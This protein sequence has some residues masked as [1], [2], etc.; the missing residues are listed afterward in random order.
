MQLIGRIARISLAGVLVFFTGC[1]SEGDAGGWSGSVEAL[2]NGAV[3]VVNPAEGLWGPEAEWSLTNELVLGQIEGPEEEVFS[4]L[5][6]LEVDDEGRIYVLDRDLN[7]LRIFSP[8]GEH[9]RSVGGPG[10][11]PGEFRAANG[12]EWLPG[13]SLL[14]ID[15]R[16]NRYSVFSREGEFARSAPRG[17]SFYAWAFRGGV[18]GENR[19]GI[20]EVRVYEMSFVP[21]G[22]ERRPALLGVPLGDDDGRMA[23]TPPPGTEG[24]PS[25]SAGNDTILLPV[26]NV[27]PYESY[28]V[29][30]DRGGMSMGVPFAP[31][32]VYHLG[33]ILEGG[34]GGLWHGH[35]SEFRIFHSFLQ[36]DTLL[37]IVVDTEPVPVSSE[38]ISEF[39]ASEAAGRFREMGGDLDLGR[40]PEFKPF[41]EGLYQDPD[42]YLWVSI[43]SEPMTVSFAVIDPDG[44]YLGRL[45]LSGFERTTFIDPVVRNGRLHLV[46]SDELGVQYVQVF[47]I[48]R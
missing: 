11:G 8:D 43:P 23:A 47:R 28:S 30:T 5:I 6:A 45:E 25:A 12:L 29:R 35:G 38:E 3:R 4:N 34:K 19:D 32:S 40:I 20:G 46:G 18:V 36:G 42:G 9:L 14:V 7:Q 48:D 1:E 31:S 27:P 15:Q 24:F 22:E 33:N 13:D 39:E 41:F 17:L 16:G 2:P 37:E 21:D 10:E 26:S 44:R